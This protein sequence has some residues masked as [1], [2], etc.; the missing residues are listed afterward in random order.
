MEHGPAAIIG[1]LLMSLEKKPEPDKI[2]RL[3]DLF[4]LDPE[5]LKDIDE[6]D[7][8]TVHFYQFTNFPAS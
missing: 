2:V 4:G 7:V 1:Y 5:S 8:V 6:D 3:D